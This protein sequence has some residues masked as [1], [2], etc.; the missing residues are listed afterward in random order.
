M[1]S[2]PTARGDE[3]DSRNLG[4]TLMAENI[5]SVT[6]DL[7][8]NWPDM[9]GDPDQRI[10]DAIEALKTAKQ[11]GVDTLVDRTVAGIGR[12]VSR[13]KRIARHSPV[14]ILVATGFYTWRDVPFRFIFQK[15]LGDWLQDKRGLEYYFQR[16]IE[17]GIG[18]TGVRAAVLKVATDR[19][20]VTEGVEMLLRA[21]ARV[22]RRTG[23]PISTH[24]NGAQAALEQCKIFE[25]EGVD[26]S[27]VYLGHVDMTPGDGIEEMLE[28]IKRGAT[29]SFDMLSSADLMGNRESRIKR[30]VELC[31][32]GHADRLGLSHEIALFSDH[33]PEVDFNAAQRNSKFAPWTEVSLGL[34]PI[35]R[36]R[37]VTADQIEQMTVRNPRRILES[38][39]LGSY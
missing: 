21:T 10:I 22:H 36:E 23:V 13:I 38:T 39:A 33:V 18:D 16:D 14:N 5:F 37:G 4:F 26:L 34:I 11:H 8:I 7:D 31:A 15:D 27:R 3:I 35:L 17:E 1:A 12:N 6:P 2:I 29:V 30:I 25:S 32:R 28:L 19:Y 24:T 20:G 9:Y